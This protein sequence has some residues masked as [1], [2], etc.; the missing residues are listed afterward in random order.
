MAALCLL[1]GGTISRD[2]HAQAPLLDR[3]GTDGYV[4]ALARYGRNLILGGQFTQVGPVTGSSAVADSG[5]SA[6]HAP[7]PRIAGTVLASASDGVGGWFLGGVFG[8]V[9]AT[10]V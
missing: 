4:Y 1:S 10:P 2:A 8:Q 6:P 3:W 9:D 5:T 7:W